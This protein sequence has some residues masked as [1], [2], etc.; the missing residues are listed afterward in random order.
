MVNLLK[1]PNLGEECTEKLAC[2]LGDIVNSSSLPTWLI[3]KSLATDLLVNVVEVLLPKQSIAKFTRSFR[4]VL[5]ETDR[6]SCE[7][8]CKDYN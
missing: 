6:S 5:N 3:S 7:H 2:K 1:D 4:S 8:E